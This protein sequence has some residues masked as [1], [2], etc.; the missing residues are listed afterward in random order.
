[1]VLI[2]AGINFYHVLGISLIAIQT[3]DSDNLVVHYWLLASKHS[4]EQDMCTDGL[5]SEYIAENC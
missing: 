5:S 2:V 1:M 3:S 4:T